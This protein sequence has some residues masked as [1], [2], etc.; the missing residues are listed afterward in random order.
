MSWRDHENDWEEGLQ[1]RF[2]LNKR[3]KKDLCSIPA[4]T[5]WRE[6]IPRELRLL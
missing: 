1:M 4:K 5:Q 3:K 6:G 2:L